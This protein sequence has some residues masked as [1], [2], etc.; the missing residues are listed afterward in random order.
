MADTIPSTTRDRHTTQNIRKVA[1]QSPSLFVQRASR[2]Y[3]HS[4]FN[5]V[6]FVHGGDGCSSRCPLRVVNQELIQ[7]DYRGA[8]FS[9]RPTE[10]GDDHLKGF[11]AFR[12]SQRDQLQSLLA[13]EDDFGEWYL[14]DDGYRLPDDELFAA[15]PWSLAG[16]GQKICA[17]FMDLESGEAWFALAPWFRIGDELNQRPNA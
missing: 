8:V 9:L 4:R 12:D 17:R 14:D 15:S 1:S 3:N 10:H 6:R 16:D 7:L 5:V 11:F 13:A 2:W